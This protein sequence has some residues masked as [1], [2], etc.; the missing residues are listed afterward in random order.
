MGRRAGPRAPLCGTGSVNTVSAARDR[1]SPGARPARRCG[2]PS[3]PRSTRTSRHLRG[4]TGA[5]L[6]ADTRFRIW[7]QQPASRGSGG[8]GSRQTGGPGEG[9]TDAAWLRRAPGPETGEGTACCPAGGDACPEGG[10]EPACGAPVGRLSI[11]NS[12]VRGLFARLLLVPTEPVICRLGVQPQDLSL[13]VNSKRERGDRGADK[14]PAET[15]E[16]TGA[17]EQTRQPRPPAT[18]GARPAPQPSLLGRGSPWPTATKRPGL[19][20]P[21]GQAAAAAGARVTGPAPGAG[22]GRA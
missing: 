15:R 14:K 11:R 5:S 8:A 18:P 6:A 10:C 3:R 16:V 1:S 21:R 20:E 19:Q 12:P 9:R 7:S 22:S 2:R 13:L 4:S 17:A